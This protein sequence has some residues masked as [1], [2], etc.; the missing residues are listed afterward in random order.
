MKERIEPHFGNL[1]NKP[2]VSNNDETITSNNI[3]PKNLPNEQ[4]I[5]G[6]TKDITPTISKKIREGKND[7][8]INFGIYVIIIYLLFSLLR[9]LGDYS[10]GIFNIDRLDLLKTIDFSGSAVSILQICIL[11]KLLTLITFSIFTFKKISKFRLYSCLIILFNSIAL[12]VLYLLTYSLDSMLLSNPLRG[13]T[14]IIFALLICAYLIFSKRVKSVF[15][16]NQT[17]EV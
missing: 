10:T 4:S 6:H 5:F 8:K 9:L 2:K 11:F 16:R 1:K 7:K 15:E 3:H 13:L 17:S 14:D 12:T